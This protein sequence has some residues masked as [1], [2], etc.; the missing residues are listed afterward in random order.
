LD[1]KVPE[2]S[3]IIEKL[4]RISEFSYEPCRQHF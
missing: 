1:C 4:P 3:P 2:D